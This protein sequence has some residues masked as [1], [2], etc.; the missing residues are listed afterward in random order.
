[1]GNAPDLANIRTSVAEYIE[2][3]FFET[4][5]QHM[6]DILALREKMEGGREGK[7]TRDRDEQA[8][9]L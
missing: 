2:E 6:R 4:Q 7:K 9:L 8:G 5:A 1:M 3:E